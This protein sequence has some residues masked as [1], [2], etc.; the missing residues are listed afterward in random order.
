MSTPC[1]KVDQV[2]IPLEKVLRLPAQTPA[3]Q[4]SK[5]GVLPADVQPDTPVM[6]EAEGK[7]LLVTTFAKLRS[8]YLPMTWSGSLGDQLSHVPPVI[9]VGAGTLLMALNDRWQ[10]LVNAGWALVVDDETAEPVGVLNVD[11]IYK[12]LADFRVQFELD[13]VVHLDGQWTL[14]QVVAQIEAHSLRDRS[15]LASLDAASGQWQVYHVSDL[16][17]AVKERALGPDETVAALVA[18]LAAEAVPAR[19]LS[20]DWAAI[21]ALFSPHASRFLML[22]DGEP[23]FLLTQRDPEETMRSGFEKGIGAP[24]SANL[25]WF[26]SEY[27]PEA[28]AQDRGVVVN[29]WFARNDASSTPVPHTHALAANQ[30]YRLGVNLGRQDER[31]HVTGEQPALD[32]RIVAYARAKDKPLTLRLDSD[33]DEF[34]VLEPEK[35]VSLARLSQAIRTDDLFFPVVTP[36]RTGLAHLRLGI[37]FENNLVQSYLISAQ[38]A[39]A[40]GEIPQHARVGWT[41]RCEY[42]LSADFANLDDLSERRVCVWIGSSKGDAW[43]AGL[44]LQGAAGLDLN[45]GISLDVNPLLIEAALKRYRQLLEQSCVQETSSGFQYLYKA[46]H[47][48]HNPQV[49]DARVK[50]LAE[51]GQSLYLRLFDTE[52][53]RAVVDELHAVERAQPGPLVVQIARLNLDITFPWAALYDRPLRYHPQRTVVCKHF[54]Q[55]EHCREHCPHIR[56]VDGSS[57]VDEN[58][59]CVY[60]FWGFRYII[61]QPLRPPDAYASIFTRL[62]AQGAPWLSLTYGTGLGL[63]EPHRQ[64]VAHIVGDRAKCTFYGAP[65]NTMSIA[66]VGGTDDLLRDLGQGALVAYFYCHGGNTP[67]L[68]WLE[69]TQADPLMPSYLDRS[70]TEAWHRTAPLVI[71][72]GCHTG[73]YDPATL[74]SFVH[75]FGAL[76]AAGVIGTEIPIHEYLG[77]AFGEF[78]LSQLLQEKPVGQIVYDF[79]RGMLKKL[80][81]L[82]LIYVPYCYADLKLVAGAASGG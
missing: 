64:Q 75:R 5:Q 78:F 55:D 26:L 54:V 82:G 8:D 32:G 46:D 17:G 6:V 18:H 40:E 50:E 11:D 34:V 7:A 44:R 67:Y 19:D 53:G 35:T 28:T 43:R 80:N 72:N 22:I 52:S 31:A 15:R 71:M 45:R 81:L 61:E 59:I 68:H 70:L 60:G 62:E 73:K 74:L 47:T 2:K 49:F 3:G 36:V 13:S 29:T 12:V 58:V 66:S 24:R 33:D 63:S 10:R 23:Q 65:S 57:Q 41:S 79:R 37:Y 14:R 38:V 4:F 30:L 69:V 48:P 77:R 56:Q 51:L 9:E 21:R 16:V 39:P 1:T 25:A 42:T 76:G 20:M 27:G